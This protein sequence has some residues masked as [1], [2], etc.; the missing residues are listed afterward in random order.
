MFATHDVFNDIYDHVTLPDSLQNL[1]F[2]SDFN[3]SLEGMT[4]PK[5]LQNLT[6][7]WHFNKSL[8][9]RDLA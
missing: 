3:Q 4:L 5:S 6:F 8:E 1:T 9:T 7:G 2:G